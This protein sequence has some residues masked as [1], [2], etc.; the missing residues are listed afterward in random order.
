MIELT[1]IPFGHRFVG[2]WE[3]EQVN[4]KKDIVRIIEEHLGIDNIAIS[5]CT[6]LNGAPYLLFIP[7]DFDSEN[8]REAWDDAKRLYNYF[9]REGYSSYLV[10][11]GR[12][13][14]HV[15]LLPEPKVYTRKQLRAIQV[16]FKNLLS[17]KTVDQQIFGDIR[18]L[19]RVP[20]TYNIGGGNLCRVLA[21]NEGKL[22][23]L[24][25][26]CTDEKVSLGNGLKKDE[27]KINQ[28]HDY[29]CIESIVRLDS[30]PR[31]LIRFTYVILKLDEGFS[32]EEIL[33]E[34]GS[35]GWL[36]YNEDYTRK[37]IE[38]IESRGYVP[39]SCDTIREMGFCSVE[40]CPYLKTSDQLLKDLGIL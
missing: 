29:P 23:N 26:F 8:L 20:G 4:S 17:L 19:M 21:K 37:Q 13:G 14:F 25:L 9:V 16:Y 36:D 5:V 7:F 15:Y 11:S 38:H 24:D 39:P 2:Y 28:Y 31:H 18:R 12:K 10:Y 32:T 22:Y 1:D 27:D 30:E 6:Y 3:Q 35:F 40:D 34:I 33:D